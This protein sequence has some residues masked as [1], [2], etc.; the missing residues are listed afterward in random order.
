MYSERC[1]AGSFQ[2]IRRAYNQLAND[3]CNRKQAEGKAKGRTY[4]YKLEKWRLLWDANGYNCG[5]SVV[6]LRKGREGMKAFRHHR[7]FMVLSSVFFLVAAVSF[8][9]LLTASDEAGEEGK[10]EATVDDVPSVAG[11]EEGGREPAVLADVGEAP[12]EAEPEVD[13]RTALVG[14]EERVRFPEKGLP[15]RTL[16]EEVRSEGSGAWLRVRVQESDFKYPLIRVEERFARNTQGQEAL[17]S[18][19]EMVADHL[20]VRLTPGSGRDALEEITRSLGATIRKKMGAP[21]SYLVSFAC[22]SVDSLDEMLEAFHAEVSSIAYA[23]PDYILRALDSVPDDALFASLWG[24]HNT[25]QTGGT[26][27]ADIDAP[28][29]WDIATGS[30][31]VLVGVIDTGVDDTHPDLA[32]NMWIN[33]GEAGALATNGVD[34]DG[35]GYVD[36]WRGWDFVNEDNNPTDDHYHGTHCAGTIGGVGNNGIGVAGV[37]WHV[38]MVALKFLN[39]GGSGA[40]SDAVDAIYYAT[41]I[42]V[43][44]TSN[45]WG[46]GG[47]TASMYDAI[48]DAA[49]HDILFVAAAGNRSSN[50]DS[51]PHYPSSYENENVLAV[52]ATDARDALAHFSCYGAESVD[53]AAPGVNINSA[54]PGNAYRSISGTSMA[55]PHV[56]GAAALIKS[57]SGHL[58][59]VAIKE[60]LLNTADPV[61]AL[62]GKCV[63]EGRLN[64]HAAL[65]RMRD[66]MVLAYDYELSDGNG[67]G[68]FNPG[69]SALLSARI[70]NVGVV[71][72]TNAVLTVQSVPGIS[73]SPQ[74]IDLGT[75]PGNTALT[76]RVAFSVTVD[77]SYST[78]DQVALDFVIADAS[79][80]TLTS[81]YENAVYRTGSVSG[82]V[83]RALDYLPLEG[84]RVTYEGPISGTVTS[85]AD[86]RFFFVL[87]DG[88][89]QVRAELS[90]YAEHPAQ[91]VEMPADLDVVFELGWPRLELM[92]EV[93]ELTVEKNSNASFSTEAL[94]SGNGAMRYSVRANGYAFYT[95]AVDYNW[96]DISATGMEITGL[97]D[98]NSSEVLGIGF[99][100]PFYGKRW[101]CL[102]VCA[103]GF[104]TLGETNYSSYINVPLPR[105]SSPLVPMIAPFWDDLYPVNSGKVFYQLIDGDKFVIQY[106]EMPYYGFPTQKLTCQ[107]VLYQS[108]E[109]AF[110]YKR[111]DRN[112]N[113]TVGLDAGDGIHG[114][115]VFHNTAGVEPG[116]LIGFNRFGAVWMEMQ[117][118]EGALEPGAS[119]VLTGA[120]HSAGL[121]AGTNYTSSWA[122]I[123]EGFE[124]PRQVEVR[125]TVTGKPGNRPPQAGD[126]LHGLIEDELLLFGCPVSDPDGDPLYI[127]ILEAPQHGVVTRAGSTNWIYRP[128]P[129]YYGEDA[130]LYTV[131]DLE[132]IRTGRVAF[133][134]APV[135]DP[136][137]ITLQY[138]RNNA[139]FSSD[140]SILFELTA[141]DPDSDI[142]EVRVWLDGVGS[143]QAARQTG[144]LY[145]CTQPALPVGT[146]SYYAT[147]TDQSGLCVTSAV[148]YFGVQHMR[149]PDEAPD[150]PLHGLVYRYYEG[151][152][153]TNLPDYASMSPLREG[154][155]RTLTL[156]S[157]C[158]RAE[159]YGLSYEGYLHAPTSGVYRLELTSDDGSRLYIGDQLVV[160][161]DGAHGSRCIY[162]S[163][164]LGQ[165][166][167][168]LRLDYFNADGSG[169]LSLECRRLN[170]EGYYTAVYTNLFRAQNALTNPVAHL[171]G[172]EEITHAREGDALDVRIEAY[173]GAG[174]LERVSLYDNG[175]WLADANY[176]NEDAY[177]HTWMS[178]PAGRHEVRAVAVDE[179]GRTAT[180]GIR[181][182]DV[183]GVMG[184]AWTNHDISPS[185]PGGWAGYNPDTKKYYVRGAGRDIWGTEDSFYYACQP[186]RGDAEITAQLESMDFTHEWAKA[187]VMIRESESPGS[188]HA[189]MLLSPVHGVAA[190]ARMEYGGETT[191]KHQT[192]IGMPCRLKLTRDDDRIEGYYS[193]DGHQWV[194][195]FSA[196]FSNLPETVF[197][198]LAVCSHNPPTLCDAVFSE[199]AVSSL[200]AIRIAA[201]SA[202]V[203]EQSNVCTVLRVSRQGYACTGDLPVRLIFSGPALNG[204]DYEEL[205]SNIIIPDGQ[206]AVELLFTPIVDEA[207]EGDEWALIGVQ[208]APPYRVGVPAAARIYITERAARAWRLRHFTLP[209]INAGSIS[210]LQDDPDCDGF[211]NFEEYVFGYNPRRF[212]R[213]PPAPVQGM[214]AEEPAGNPVLRVRCR[215]Y[216]DDILYRIETS[217]DLMHWMT[218]TGTPRRVQSSD[219]DDEPDLQ[220]LDYEVDLSGAE[221]R[222]HF[223]LHAQEVDQEE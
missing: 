166:Y 12:G 152:G 208:V 26:A 39:A 162:G 102:R 200:A 11:T 111:M 177:L 133:T 79:G 33:P 43:D 165:G 214:A 126:A 157:V 217:A 95:N 75:V 101:D 148:R 82:R 136:S 128:A 118:S 110:Q 24:M 121:M 185:R 46:G 134:I 56:A 14:E 62:S 53:M 190:H 163:I 210:G 167:H 206:E 223:R 159:D 106:E 138:P 80:G 151:E 194:P 221:G 10:T 218:H 145:Q 175:L 89:Y 180:S 211:S 205:P 122:V 23:E 100:F 35:N 215:P 41:G 209:E 171:V 179:Y 36:D 77:G 193:M 3:Q 8:L 176:L 91:I 84:A 132:E 5:V 70:K 154:R 93:I 60:L 172:S 104:V 168:R 220:W 21:D 199:T 16:F 9:C 48:E 219:A 140:T 40:L 108:G 31:N 2:C 107:A 213:V 99:D 20:I 32:A 127:E 96:M 27:G 71:A 164:G 124:E 137:T 65:I 54:S 105:T 38:S 112:G 78:P 28:Q 174:A 115:T 83:Q 216:A 142:A 13:D 117:D 156:S 59:A 201:Q 19:Q 7:W 161:N 51:Y 125:L 184:A 207:V 173:A 155:V 92:P 135:N 86:G 66:S 197:F 202:S 160:N 158:R 22:E 67:D 90:G 55:T 147:V 130:L 181:R 17:L 69:E 4:V 63:C 15:G 150:A 187:G 6:L 1:H 58:A 153:W 88:T 72:A 113:G 114:L 195:H 123:N 191:N 37:C 57:V 204:E 212:E 47:R 76:N 183:Y 68:W 182:V 87:V 129:D 149:T 116:M 139:V 146:Y 45:S 192:G 144:D 170:P 25:G 203:A 29:A 196:T 44:L 61:S 103:N 73:V 98:D 131:T 50:N 178:L 18:R 74:S 222:A 143:M 169:A 120:V 49:D 188:P 186:V 94:N 52:A 109:V 97:F 81:R 34:D 119:V 189:M 85:D 64:L 30:T 42:G 141:T 198:G